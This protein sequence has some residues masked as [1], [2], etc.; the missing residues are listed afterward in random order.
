MLR[1]TLAAEQLLAGRAT[2]ARGAAA[3]HLELLV[4]DLHYHGGGHRGR[5]PILL[6]YELGH[7]LLQGGRTTGR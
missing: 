3:A 5:V 4:E 2:R 7:P 1:S 6:E